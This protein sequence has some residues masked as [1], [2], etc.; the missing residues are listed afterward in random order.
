M[1]GLIGRRPLPM[2][3]SSWRY[4]NC[5]IWRTLLR[6]NDGGP[7]GFSEE[8]P[9]DAYLNNLFLLSVINLPKTKVVEPMECM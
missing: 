7:D 3:D 6:S 1:D 5:R 4:T 9:S 8:G 2:V